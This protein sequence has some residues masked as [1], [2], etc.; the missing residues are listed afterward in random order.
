MRIVG[1]ETE[2]KPVPCRLVVELHT[3]VTLYIKLTE[4][5]EQQ[6]LS[7]FITDTDKLYMVLQ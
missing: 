4:K 3:L 1:F 5:V 6:T 7:S 2:T